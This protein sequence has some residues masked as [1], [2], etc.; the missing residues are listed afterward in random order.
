MNEVLHAAAELQAVC[1]R[2]QWRF[3][4]IGGV[5]LLRWGAPRET[6]DADLTLLAEF[7][8]EQKFARVLLRHFEGRIPNVEAFAAEQRVILL[9]SKSGV[10]LDVALGGLPFEESAVK[11][12]SLFEFAPECKLRS[13]SAEDLI[14]FK[15]FA[16]RQQDWADIEQI[17]IAQS[18]KLDWDYIHT[19]L[20]PLVALKERPD[21]VETLKH[22]RREYE[23]C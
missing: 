4:F 18:G 2:E 10:G 16:N 17:I 6:V 11:R 9:R 12:S 14:V 23:G 19:Q 15:A 22:H 5:A 1:E 21:I 7:G 13:C 8:Q 20:E 3:C